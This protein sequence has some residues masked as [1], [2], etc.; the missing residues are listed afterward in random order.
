MRK[1]RKWERMEIH[2]SFPFGERYMTSRFILDEFDLDLS[3]TC[4]FV[5]FRLFLFIVVVRS[6]IDCILVVYERVI[7]YG[8]SAGRLRMMLLGVTGSSGVGSWMY[9]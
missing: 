2:A 7:S 5:R 4:L 1:E 3:P 8:W 6:G 9:I